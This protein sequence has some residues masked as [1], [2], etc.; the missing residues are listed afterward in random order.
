M[1]GELFLLF[2]FFFFYSCK[3]EKK[4]T[5]ETSENRISI[6]DVEKAMDRLSNPKFNFSEFVED[7]TY[8]PLQ[9]TNESLIG[10]KHQPPL[11]VSADYIFYGDMMFRRDGRFIRKL[12]K[13]GQGPEEYLQALGIAI[14]EER[15][16][17]YVYTNFDRNIYIYDFNNRFKK[18]MQAS[19]RSRSISSLGNGKIALLRDG[20]GYFDDFYEYRVIDTDKGDISYTRN[21]GVNENE[22]LCN[23]VNS[24]WRYNQDVYYYEGSTDTIFHLNENGEIDSPRYLINSGKYKNQGDDNYLRITGFV[25]SSQYLFFSI[26]TKKSLHYGAYNKQTEKTV[27]NKF[28]EFFNNDID[29]GF[30]WLFD[31]TSDGKEGFYSIFPYL[32]KERIEM[33]SKQNTGYDKEK[34]Q[35]LRQLIDRVDEE[36]NEIFYFL[37]LK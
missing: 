19:D 11:H 27:I 28:D 29:G 18:K 33:L 7:I 3:S 22:A 21:S 16:E 35:R 36:D 15:E 5:E 30:L 1:K 24:I 26:H 12:G 6:I 9:T 10:G 8:I 13:T 37:K 31:S 14:D 32:A 25:E 23:I 2:V 34:N 4:A 17:F 20:Y